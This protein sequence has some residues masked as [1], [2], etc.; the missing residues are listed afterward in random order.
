V[1]SA[2]RIRLLPFQRKL[3]PQLLTLA[4]GDADWVAQQLALL[5]NVGFDG[6][7]LNFVNYLDEFPYFVQEVLPRLERLGVRNA[8][9]QQAID[10]G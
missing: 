10:G 6:L 9:V 1:I 4:L 5:R 7:V 2:G 8:R 3:F